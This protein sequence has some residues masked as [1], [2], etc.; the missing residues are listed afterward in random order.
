MAQPQSQNTPID[1]LHRHVFNGLARHNVRTPDSGLVAACLAEHVDLADLIPE[2]AGELRREFGPDAELSRELYRDPEVSDEY[3]TLYV[4][5]GNYSSD[6]L[7]RIERVS[8]IFSD[9]LAD[10]S[11]YILVTTDFRSPKES[12]AV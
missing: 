10:V 5:Q 6:I 4:R 8:E 2:L 7:L 3:L 11:G 1:E 12:H 9:P